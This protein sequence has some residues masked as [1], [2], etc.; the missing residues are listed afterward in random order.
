LN[1]SDLDDNEFDFESIKDS[2]PNFN[3]DILNQQLR[4]SVPMMGYGERSGMI[5]DAQNAMT[6]EGF[7]NQR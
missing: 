6:Q 1:T 4:A 7:N 3:R 2:N 5:N